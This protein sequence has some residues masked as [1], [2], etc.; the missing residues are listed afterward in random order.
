[1]SLEYFQSL[2]NEP[3]GNS[4]IKRDYLKMY[5]Q[6]G[7]QLNQSDQNVEFFSVKT[8]IIIKWVMVI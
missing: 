6:Q 8:T 7:A 5:H 2:D 4:I 3:F 1:M